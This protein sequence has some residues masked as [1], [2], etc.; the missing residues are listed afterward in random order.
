MINDNLIN[1]Q[2]AI[3]TALDFFVE[4]LGGAFHE[5]GQKE[6]LVRFQRLPSAQPDVPDT[7]IGDMISRQAAIDAS[8][9]DWCGCTYANCPNQFNLESERFCD[10]CDTVVTLKKMPSAQHDLSEYSD[11]LWKRAYDRGYEKC[12]QD[13]ND[14]LMEILDR[15]NHA[16]FL[17]TD[18]ICK[19]LNGLPSAQPEWKSGKWT[20]CSE[21]LPEEHIGFYLVTVQKRRITALNVVGCDNTVPDIDIARWDYDRRAPQRGYHWC[22]ADKVIAWMPLPE[23]YRQKEEP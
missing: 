11:R 9:K 10:G 12:R 19:V 17:Y 16:E 15:P 8:C 4:F 14:A 3:D 5:D 13:A 23:P 21:R 20:P 22:K 7:N 1:R 18:E 6:L 2:M